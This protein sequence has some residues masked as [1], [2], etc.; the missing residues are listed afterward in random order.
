MRLEEF[1]QE[2]TKKGDNDLASAQFLMYMR[3]VPLEVIGFHC[4]QAVEKYLKAYLVL[5]GVEPEKTH[6]LGLLLERC[7][8]FDAGFSTLAES[9]AFLTDFAV[10][11]RYPNSIS[12]DFDTI[13]KALSL[14]RGA[15]A[16]V[17]SKLAEGSD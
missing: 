9:C 17:A 12:L 6:D 5:K 8:T 10:E 13:S 1:V 14:A 4:Q 3:P 11:M 2:W 7:S 16:H 15:V